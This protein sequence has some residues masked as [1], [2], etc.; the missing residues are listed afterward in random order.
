MSDTKQHTA[1][2]IGGGMSGLITGALL[3][4]NGYK[5]TVLEKNHIV[6]GGLQ[7]FRRGDAIFNT[8]MQACAGYIPGM[9]SY[10]VSKYLGVSNKIKLLETASEKQ[11]IIWLRKN[12]P[13]CLPKGRDA[14]QAYLVQLFPHEEK[15]IKELL[16][17]VFRIGH[18]F[19]YLFLQ[20]IQRYEENVPYAY[21]TAYELIRIYIND[22]NLVDIFE[23]V[24]WTTGHCLKM[25]PALEFCMMLT[26]YIIG[27]H[28]FINGAKQLADALCNVIEQ[29]GGIVMN[30]TEICEV[31]GENDQISYISAMD[32]RRWESE[33][34]VW[35]CT[36]KILLDICE[37]HVFRK[38]MTQRIQEYIN[39]FTVFVVFCQLKKEKFKFINSSVYIPKLQRYKYLPQSIVF[40]TSPRKESDQWAESMEIYIPANYEDLI[41]WEDTFVGDRGDEY[42]I[43]KEQI[44]RDA[45]NTISA[46]YPEISDAI[47]SINVASGLTIRDYYGNP[48][49]SCYGQQGLYIPIKTKL[50]NLYMTGQAVQNQGL[51]GIATTSVLTAETILGKSLIEE[52]AKA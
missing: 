17:C 12:N 20:P 8:G 49:G 41:K 42:E 40:V 16:N 51:A 28:R 29:N 1:C 25:M 30:D 37:E 10:Q 31:K 3:A 18:T 32:G 45:I 23:Y 44:A 26:L 6:G 47:M 24:G 21:M 35:A 13:V 52:I 9:I 11:E 38:S 15:G 43:Y 4:K 39:P 14:Y 5:V 36:P 2:I 34:F 50:K 22:D 19:D 46:Y 33:N 7:S 27:S 48:R